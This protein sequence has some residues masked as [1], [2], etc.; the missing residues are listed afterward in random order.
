ML[1][2]KK[3]KKNSK[4]EG[5]D[6]T[7][8]EVVNADD[9]FDDIGEGVLGSNDAPLPKPPAG[10]V[11]DDHGRLVM[12]SPPSKRITT[13]VST[14]FLL[15]FLAFPPISLLICTIIFCVFNALL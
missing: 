15:F 10:F 5:L 14:Y 9:D 2:K 1:K 8:V 7:N 11:V 12:A 13:I 4:D 3:K 6:F